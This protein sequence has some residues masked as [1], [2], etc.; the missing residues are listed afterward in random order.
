M[1][2]LKVIF[3][4]MQ[5]MFTRKNINLTTTL[6]YYTLVQKVVNLTI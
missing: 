5:I 2:I 6:N 1:T 3:H 4:I